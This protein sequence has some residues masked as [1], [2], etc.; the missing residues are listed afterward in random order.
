MNRQTLYFSALQGA[1]KALGED[2]LRRRLKV[3]AAALSAWLERER[4]IPEAVF[5]AAVDILQEREP[6]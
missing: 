6:R 3:P 2:R 4:P 5:L 1:A